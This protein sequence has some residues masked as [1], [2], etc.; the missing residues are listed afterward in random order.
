MIVYEV[1]PPPQKKSMRELL[2][3]VINFTN[4]AGYKINSN[5]SIAFFYSR[6]KWAE[7]EDREMKPF[8]VVTNNIE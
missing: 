7:I 3:L 6:D 8:T 1:T 4:V 5:K 2:Q